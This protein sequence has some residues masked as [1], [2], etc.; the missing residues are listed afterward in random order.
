[1]GCRSHS[2]GLVPPVETAL[3]ANDF[4]EVIDRLADSF[5]LLWSPSSKPIQRFDELRQRLRDKRLNLAVLGQ[6][7][8]G[9][10]TVI[11]ALLGEALLPTG[12]VPLTA[13][14]T[15]IE[16]GRDPLIRVSFQSGCG[17][18]EYRPNSAQETRDQLF[19]FVAE[20]ANPKNRLG[21][22]KVMLFYPARFL[23][24]G[25]VLIDTPGIGSTYRHNTDAAL[26]ALQD[27]DVALFV[28]SADPPITEAE[29]DY[30]KAV[31]GKV[32]HVIF[33]L[34]KADHL[35]PHER[36]IAT[37]FLERAIEGSDLSNGAPNIFCLAALE[38]VEAK[39]SGDAAAV[40][41]SGLYD[42]E[43]HL[44]R[45]LERDKVAGIEAGA[46]KKMLGLLDTAATETALGIRTLEMPLV[47]LEQ[48]IAVFDQT[49]D[50]IEGENKVIHDL[51]AGDRRRAVKELEARSD[52]LRQDAQHHFLRLL[53]HALTGKSK[54]SAVEQTQAAIAES[55][56]DYF[57]D[58]LADMS[59]YVTAQV[60]QM[61]QEHQ[62]R[63]DR[64]VDLVRQK[65]A[66]I[67]DIPFDGSD[68]AEPF[69]MSA[70]PYW[71]GRTYDMAL[72]DV[73]A[74]LIDWLLP[75]R[76]RQ[77]RRKKR[78]RLEIEALVRRNVENLRWS[79]LRGIDD[80]FRRFGAFLD[81]RLQAATDATQ[82]AA[83]AAAERRHSTADGIE[84]ELEK[85]QRL[86]RDFAR[87]RAAL[88]AFQ[89]GMDNQPD[90]SG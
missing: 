71:I 36:Q 11:N 10:S 29:V 87:A 80:T 30:L 20:E 40:E 24:R 18:E 85:L 14:P 17:I 3:P 21:V 59:A 57:E 76:L 60:D 67:F 58:E 46:I 26:D 47:D 55:I 16:W 63:I 89:N 72:N 50:R 64:L 15:F 44:A 4:A 12:I 35:Q 70:S 2:P 32:A 82:G 8:R 84:A 13:I 74:G 86:S 22:A 90:S 69:Q 62:G 33:V 54:T 28:I 61:L 81:N 6:F 38:G 43:T 66:D 52:R 25:V 48:R 19:K 23:R 27:C 75:S 53:N 49:L 41:S 31:R 65:A 56:S 34:N 5:A 1:M 42:L 45:Y 9:K 37:D 73:A 77:A 51:L 78:L 88:L 39:Q 7:K 79:T 68:D 83:Q